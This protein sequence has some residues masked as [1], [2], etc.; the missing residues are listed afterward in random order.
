MTDKHPLTDEIITEIALL[1]RYVEEHGRCAYIGTDLS[2]EAAQRLRE[3]LRPTTT[4]E[5]N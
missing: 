1:S 3:A 2:E 5:D 4:Q